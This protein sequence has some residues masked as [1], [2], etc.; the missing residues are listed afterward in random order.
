M[1]EQTQRQRDERETMLNDALRVIEWLKD[2]PETP[3]PPS[4][5]EF[6]IYAWDSKEEAAKMAKL[7]GT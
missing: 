3:L 5:G 7:M 6:N 4:P 2:H 1:S